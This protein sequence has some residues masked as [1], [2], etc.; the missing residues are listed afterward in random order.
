MTLTAALLLVQTIKPLGQH[1]LQSVRALAGH[2]AD[3]AHKQQMH[4]GSQHLLEQNA[5]QWLYS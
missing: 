4:K 5:S 1:R 2:V 3:A